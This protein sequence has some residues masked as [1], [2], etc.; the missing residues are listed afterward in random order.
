MWDVVVGVWEE[1]VWI[2]DS[3]VVWVIGMSECEW[4]MKVVVSYCE[5]V[6]IIWVSFKNVIE[7]REW[8]FK[9]KFLDDDNECFR[10]VIIWLIYWLDVLWD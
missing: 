10:D 1:V 6:E 9:N 8:D 7:I 2:V 5:R 4:W 3:F